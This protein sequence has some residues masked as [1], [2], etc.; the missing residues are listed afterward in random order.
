MFAKYPGP[1]A[2]VLPM[3]CVPKNNQF[4]PYIM[5][6]EELESFFDAADRLSFRY[7][8]FLKTTIPVMLRFIYACG[9][10]PGEA[11]RLKADDID[12]KTGEIFIKNTKRHKDRII[13]ASVS[14]IAMLK[15]YDSI[16]SLTVDSTEYFFCAG[17]GSR[18]YLHQLDRSVRRCWIL[19]HPETEPGD[20]PMIRAY[21]FR[22][23][24]ASAVLQAPAG[25]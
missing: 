3:N 23:R 25:Q 20:L 2:Y 9:L 18:I 6:E 22:H 21:D 19:C 4:I 16:R 15:K 5:T 17:D 7:D 11:L 8:S 1:S 14:V 10:R 12:L 13:V 24:F